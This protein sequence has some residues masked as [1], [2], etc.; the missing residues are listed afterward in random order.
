[1]AQV[2]ISYSR[3]DLDFV[4]QLAADLK[5]AGLGV[6]YDVSGIT[7]G[8]RWRTE[9]ENALQNSQYVVV[10]LSPDSITSE[11]V[12]REFLF[13]SDINLKIIPI[14]YRQCKLPLNYLNLNY[15]DVREKNYQNKF[16]DLLQALA[17]EPSK[18]PTKKQSYSVKKIATAVG[19]LFLLV[20]VL[21]GIKNSG[22]L[23]SLSLG[24]TST[25]TSLPFEP[26]SL[27]E[28]IN[29]GD[30]EML[31]IPAGSF[32]M[33]NEINNTLADCK[34][35]SSKCQRRWF[36]DEAPSQVIYQTDFY[37][38]KYEVTNVMYQACVQEGKC[39][40]P[41]KTASSTQESY[42]DNPRFANYPVV[43][44]NWDMANIYCQWRRTRLPT[45]IEWEKA[46]RGDNGNAYPW[47]NEFAAENSN[48]CDLNCSTSDASRE[49]DDSYKEIAPSD[50]YFKGASQ[51]G[52]YNMSGNVEEW[53]ENWYQVYPGGDPTGSDFFS[54]PQK[55]RV[56]RGGSWKSTI[57]WL[58]TTNR[59]PK[60]P[61]SADD[62]TGFR[63]AVDPQP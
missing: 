28:T 56:V 5:N 63:C 55:Y 13:A 17:V 29:S 62:Y 2:F 36:E 39:L 33:G 11:W 44:V 35:Y 43:H 12:E 27:Q 57:D 51:Y 4:N 40:P 37:I 59:D 10:V 38:D 24:P 7:G 15:I 16:P 61:K 48:F 21:L 30:A 26:I 34:K 41:L 31:L 50:S 58:R 52:V 32:T 53:V 1:M 54:P 45:E 25:A 9:I 22:I 19:V 23:Y 8:S 60:V 46:A 3:K 18:V 14:M 6:W 47:G 42:Y 20:A 49:Y